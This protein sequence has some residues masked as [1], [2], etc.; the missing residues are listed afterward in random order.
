[1]NY[2]K[3]AFALLST[4]S[5]AAIVAPA[6]AQD[7]AQPQAAATP[8][9]QAKSSD[10]TIVV[11][12]SRVITNGNNF[13][14]P[15][16]VVTTQQ[17]SA[18]TPSNIPDGLNKLPIFSGSRSQST[19]GSQ[20]V[21]SGGNYL[22]LR[23][24][25][26]VRNL[27]LFDGH[28]VQPT[29]SEGTIDVNMLPQML[30]QRV[31]VVTGGVSAVYGSDAV[32]G[33]VNFIVDRKFNGLKAEAQAGISQRG[34]AESQRFGIA[35]GTDLFGGRGHILASFEHYN[36]EGLTSNSARK[37]S[38]RVYTITGG[39]TTANPYRL[40]PD[41]RSFWINFNGR[42][43]FDPTFS[44]PSSLFEYQF[45]QNGVLTPFNHGAPSAEF[46]TESGGDGGF[47]EPAGI[48][49]S[50]RTD[51]AFLRFDYDLTDDVRFYAQGSYTEA[52]NE[53]VLA[54]FLYIFK[55]ID[56]NNAYLPAAARTILQNAGESGFL[57]GKA[58]KN[59]DPLSADVRSRNIYANAGIAGTIF[60]GADFDF[61]YTH[62]ENRARQTS[63]NNTDNGR[64]AAALDAVVGPNGQVVCNVTLTNP[65][66][67][68]GC[69][70][71][72]PFG[73]TS[74]SQASIDYVRQDT[75]YVLTNKMDD[76]AFSIVGSPIS[77][78]AGPVRMAFTAEYRHQSLRNIS[79]NQPTT[80][81][82][83]GLRFNCVPGGTTV[84]VSNVSADAAGS[85]TVKEAA[86]EIDMPLLKDSAIARSM[87]L[88][89]AVRYADYRTSG[90]A[91]TWK[92]G[93]DWHVNDDLS[94]RATRSRDFRAP[95]LYDLFQPV[96]LSRI[97]FTDPHTGVNGVTNIQFQGNTNLKPE[98]GNTL[99]FGGVYRPGWAP[100]L[101][102]AIDY[103]KIE[104]TDAITPLGGDA[105]TAQECE[106]SGGTSPLCAL[107]IRPG[108]FSDRSAANYPTLL[109]TQSL[110]AA[111]LKSHGI[112]A[113]LNYSVPI[114]EGQLN[115]RGLLSYQPELSTKR[116]PASVAIDAAGAANFSKWKATAFVTYANGP[117]TIHLQERWRS[118]QKQSGDPRLVFAIPKVPAV[119]YTDMTLT[120]DVKGWGGKQQFFLSVQN[121]FDKNS[122]VYVPPGSSGAPGYGFPAVN[123]DDILGRYF[124]AGFKARF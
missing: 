57:L 74:E 96:R 41:S 120:F 4:C 93:L 82:C 9:D 26:I 50:L 35:G 23:N 117:F 66:L 2:A 38:S 51:Q 31:D 71:I 59:A 107:F 28:R 39:G 60:G 13:P 42:P 43:T 72:N 53:Y 91:W 1:M 124:T 90:G 29:S 75:S 68:P 78:W 87:N 27:I 49:A 69:I 104:I 12:G 103:Y 15:V 46:G 99:T 33:V 84:F 63:H 114:G 37:N 62:G 36:S 111:S 18:V 14:T 116:T 17:L 122:P 16:T 3:F 11:T 58:Q 88:N 85:Q 61:S 97:G 77:S 106:L 115:L 20:D 86:V 83:T 118:A 113:E 52:R 121:L 45:G 101:S 73:P 100:G 6:M 92:V 94:F 25:G 65:G 56:A 40:T 8:A 95:T 108:P 105:V 76:V 110:N 112:D 34:D 80:L 30:I 54:P 55:Y 70:P 123:G 109:L 48:T 67:Y 89:G 32:T 21:N 10:E 5:A 64:L 119:A 22:N 102:M 79:S 24:I 81:D 98:V 47:V 19:T 7:E 44:R